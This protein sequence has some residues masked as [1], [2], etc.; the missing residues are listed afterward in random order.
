MFGFEAK[1]ALSASSPTT[2]TASTISGRRL[3]T[4]MCDEDGGIIDDLIV[5]HPGDLE[6]PDR[7]ERAIVRSTG[8]GY[9]ASTRHS[10]RG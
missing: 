10:R 7:G 8:T 3:Y 5:Y 4:V 2:W 9:L 6:V 1:D